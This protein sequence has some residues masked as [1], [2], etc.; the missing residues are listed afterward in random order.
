M[1]EWTER[2]KGLRKELERERLLVLQLSAGLDL[3]ARLDERLQE[4]GHHITEL[5]EQNERME[6]RIMSLE[7]HG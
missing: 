2:E 5:K 7:G 1:S 3:V 6:R 4:A